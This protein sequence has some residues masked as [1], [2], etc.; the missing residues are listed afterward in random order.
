MLYL[1]AER[2][3]H[4]PWVGGMTVSRYPFR[5]MTNHG[6]SLFEKLLGCLHI[7]LFAQPGIDQVAISI[8]GP[9]Q[10]APLSM[11]ACP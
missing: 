6:K 11:N 10:G 9:I 4:C 2:F 3:T 8:N 1:I 7:S 5:G